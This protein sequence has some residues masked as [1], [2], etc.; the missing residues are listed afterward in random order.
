M[1]DD[2]ELM[3][4]AAASSSSA[5][6]SSSTR[7]LRPGGFRRESSDVELQDEFQSRTLAE[8][9]TSL[10]VP[11]SRVL[12]Q[13]EEEQDLV[14]SELSRCKA[15][16]GMDSTILSARRSFHS[17][18]RKSETRTNGRTDVPSAGPE[19]EERDPSADLGSAPVASL[20]RERPPPP[21]EHLIIIIIIQMFSRSPVKRK[22]TENPLILF[23]LIC[24]AREDRD[25]AGER[26]NGNRPTEEESPSLTSAHP[27][28]VCQGPDSITGIASDTEPSLTLSARRSF[29]LEGLEKLHHDS[30]DSRQRRINV[31][32]SGL[33][34]EN[35][36]S[37]VGGGGTQQSGI[38]PPTSGPW[39]VPSVFLLSRAHGAGSTPGAGSSP[40]SLRGS[41]RLQLPGNS[42]PWRLLVLC[43]GSRRPGRPTRCRRQVFSPLTDRKQEVHF[44]REVPLMILLF[45]AEIKMSSCRTE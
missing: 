6:H 5:D 15:V 11:L 38:E 41:L 44:Y 17:E 16:V 7:Q 23:D 4:S 35:C 40:D 12:T 27:H 34:Q 24:A 42:D 45:R 18:G 32:S 25:R 26:E 43:T 28:N 8:G 39:T 1:R 9:R 30:V 13:E 20:S 3:T 14:L 33:E 29:L 22:K 2:E 19:D 37:L 10:S 21:P 36:D 31:A